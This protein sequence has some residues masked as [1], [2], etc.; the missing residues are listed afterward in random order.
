MNDPRLNDYI[1]DI[2][3]GRIQ[4]QKCLCCDNNGKEYWDENGEGV[5][6]FPRPEWGENY[7]VGACENCEGLG[8]V[9]KTVVSA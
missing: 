3:L 6:A 4:F 9:E 1:R 2:I 7:S 8:F 5:C